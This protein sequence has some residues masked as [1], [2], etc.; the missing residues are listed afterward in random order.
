MPKLFDLLLNSF[1]RVGNHKNIVA[2]SQTEMGYFDDFVEYVQACPF[3]DPRRLVE[4]RLIY[5]GQA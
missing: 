3:P 2:I 1:S 5:R 4:N